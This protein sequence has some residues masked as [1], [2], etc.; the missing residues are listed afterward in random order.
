VHKKKH[1]HEEHEEHV[2]HEAW[3]IPY[4]DMLT[5]LM[6]L[7]LVM[8]ATGQTDNNKLKAVSA[9]FADSLGITGNGRGVGGE[10]V[11]DGAAKPDT[12]AVP[13]IKP[14]LDDGKTQ[15]DK[16]AYKALEQQQEAQ[17]EKAQTDERLKEIQDKIAKAAEGTPAANDLH[18]R[19]EARGLVVSIVT[20]GVLF[21]A[22]SAD[23]R[24]EGRQILDEVAAPLQGLTNQIAIE[25]H[26]DDRPIA[27][28]RFPSNWELSTARATSVL[29]Y[30]IDAH[31][32]GGDH[33][34]ASGYADQRPVAPGHD[35]AS[36]AQNR[37]VDIAVLA[38][39][40]VVTTPSTDTSTTSPTTTV[41]EQGHE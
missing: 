32:L 2:N 20:E 13:D 11:M 29:R 19:I 23:L 21:D 12:G 8:W 6:A 37:R 40:P 4:A 14:T 30:L 7:F 17:T 25:G 18:F 31:H 1:D 39:A 28:G 15:Q 16:D 33:L 41:Q 3:V 26:T 24:P 27:T 35:D 10:G 34:T 9:G 5:L 38:P 36:R 22:G